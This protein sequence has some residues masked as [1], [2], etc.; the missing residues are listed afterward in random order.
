[1]SLERRIARHLKH[2]TPLVADGRTDVDYLTY[3]ARGLTGK[4][5]RFHENHKRVDGLLDKM[6]PPEI[7]VYD[8]PQ[9]PRN[10]ARFLT[11]NREA[12]NWVEALMDGGGQGEVQEDGTRICN[13]RG[14]QVF[15]FVN[16]EM[17]G[18]AVAC[19]QQMGYPV[20]NADAEYTNPYELWNSRPEPIEVDTSALWTDEQERLFSAFCEDERQRLGRELTDEEYREA[21]EGAWTIFATGMDLAV[22]NA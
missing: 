10:E 19:F 6:Q 11:E 4:N 22:S 16:P 12:K 21:R 1:M 15:V 17:W 9:L 2:G 18:A 20:T 3:L 5:I 13:P 14:L 8:D 7:T